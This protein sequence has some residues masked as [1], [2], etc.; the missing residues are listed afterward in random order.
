MYSD[1]SIKKELGDK[2]DKIKSEVSAQ[3]KALSRQ[4][5]DNQKSL[6]DKLSAQEK[7]NKELSDKIGIKTNKCC[8]L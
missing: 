5:T 6:Q 1:D 4:I 7:G 2:I 8:H 3:E